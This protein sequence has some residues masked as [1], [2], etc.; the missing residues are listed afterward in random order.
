VIYVCEKCGLAKNKEVHS[1]DSEE[2]TNCGKTTWRETNACEVGNIFKLGTKFTSAFGLTYSDKE[3]KMQT[4]I[5][6]C[7]G[8][9][10][11]RLMGVIAELYND[12]F[13]LKW[14]DAVTPYKIHLLTLQSKNDDV[15]K[16]I[17]DTGKNLYNEL[18]DSGLEVLFDNREETAGS[19]F[20]DSDLIGLPYR[21]VISEKTLAQN[22]VEIKKR[23]DGSVELVLL[24]DVAALL[25]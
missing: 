11:S 10:T 14:P 21:L 12:E 3:G 22:S 8:I 16:A 6:G 17:A 20:K 1:G 13:G 25:R 4:P 18:Q 23:S 5:M 9:G 19:K 24:K 2:C 7:Y 15:N